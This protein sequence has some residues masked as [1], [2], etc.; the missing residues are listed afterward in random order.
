[1]GRADLTSIL[2]SIPNIECQGKC[3]QSCGSIIISRDEQTMIREWCRK[4]GVKFHPLPQ[5]PTA[6]HLRQILNGECNS[7]KYLTDD[8]RCSI[9][10]VRP[11]ICR[12]FGVVDAM[13]CTFGCKPPDRILTAEEGQALMREA[14][15]NGTCHER[16][17]AA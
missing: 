1:M 12:L 15:Q 3:H 13:P 17:M 4:N 2:A 6:L 14:R 16:G 5:K 11:I 7:C 8:K 9:H 10:P